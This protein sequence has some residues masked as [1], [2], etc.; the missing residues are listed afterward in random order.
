MSF[1]KSIRRSLGINFDSDEEEKPTE[2]IMHEEPARAT[3]PETAD[4]HGISECRPPC[5]ADDNLPAD[6]LTA[7]VELFNSTQPEFVSRCIDTDAQKQFLLERTEGFFIRR[8]LS[9]VCFPEIAFHIIAV[10]MAVKAILF[11]IFN[12]F[13]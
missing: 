3:K 12:Q 10:K 6:M 4:D 9:E 2:N 13:E 8:K 11:P 1:I 7:V 5:P